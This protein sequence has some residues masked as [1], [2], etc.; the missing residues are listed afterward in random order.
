MKQNLDILKT[1]VQEYLE[2]S[3]MVVYY[4]Y[5]RTLDHLPIVMWDVDHHPEYERFV[6]AAKAV[7]TQLIVFHTRQFM[8]EFVDNATDDLEQADVTADERR[9][10]ERRLREMRAYDGFTCALELS[11]DH[12]GRAY[13]FEL[14]T[15]WYNDFSDLLGEINLAIPPEDDD[16]HDD[17]GPIGGFFSKN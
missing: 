11:F 4:G 6:A 10:Y 13:I 9:A 1:E 5:S 3:G 17:E 15:D 8:S 2:K 16:E 7:G 12:G 14:R